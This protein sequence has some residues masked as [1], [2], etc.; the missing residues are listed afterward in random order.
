MQ[1]YFQH[2]VCNYYFYSS[3]GLE[4]I[5]RFSNLRKLLYLYCSK[6]YKTLTKS[7]II[8]DGKIT[9]FFCIIQE[10]QKNYSFELNKNLFCH[11]LIAIAEV[12]IT[13]KGKMSDSE[14]LPL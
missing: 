10:Y 9:V 11:R 12:N 14:Q 8:T 2:V 7:A 6:I 5:I 3:S 13:V 4:I 1:K